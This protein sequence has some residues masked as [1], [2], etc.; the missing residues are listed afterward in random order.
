MG[1][2]YIYIQYSETV[3]AGVRLGSVDVLTQQLKDLEKVKEVK[4]IYSIKSKM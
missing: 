1:V 3:V 2:I 4:V